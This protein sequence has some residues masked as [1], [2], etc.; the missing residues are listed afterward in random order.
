[1]LPSVDEYRA[2]ITEFNDGSQP[3]EPY[4]RISRSVFEAAIKLYCDAHRLI[5]LRFGCKVLSV[6]ESSVTC[7]TIVI[8][9]AT[10]KT[11]IYESRYVVRCDGASSIVRRG[12]GIPLD[13]GPV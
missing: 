6:V 10:T 9:L 8:N 12:L 13:G 11:I 3:Q 4:Q 1:M 2:A 5:E 7:D